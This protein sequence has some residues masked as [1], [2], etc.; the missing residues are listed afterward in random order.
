MDFYISGTLEVGGSEEV[1]G[2]HG[3]QSCNPPP[4]PKDNFPEMGKHHVSE[5]ITNSKLKHAVIF[6]LCFF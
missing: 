4:P 5:C 6:V 3:L 2:Q 1:Q